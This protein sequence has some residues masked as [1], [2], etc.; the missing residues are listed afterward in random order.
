MFNMLHAPAYQ[1]IR[2]LR[3]AERVAANV[4]IVINHST[5]FISWE[6]TAGSG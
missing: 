6:Q 4:P 3:A 2:Q 5:L 1:P